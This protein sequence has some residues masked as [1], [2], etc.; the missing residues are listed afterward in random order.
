MGVVTSNRVE[1]AGEC[2]MVLCGLLSVL[3]LAAV[4]VEEF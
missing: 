4:L 1:H 2:L 3:E